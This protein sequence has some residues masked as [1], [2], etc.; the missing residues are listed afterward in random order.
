[1]GGRPSPGVGASD[2]RVLVVE[3]DRGFATFLEVALSGSRE[4]AS[5]RTAFDLAG[6]LEQLADG[7]VGAVL[8]DLNLPDSQGLATLREVLAT[9]PEVAVVVLTGFADEDLA[10]SALRLGAQDWLVKGELEPA[11]IDRALRYAIERTTLTKGLVRAQK[12]EAIGRLASDVAH[13]FNNV[14]TAILGSAHL[15][16]EA[17]TP[18]EREAA[19]ALL[20]RSARQGTAL[21]RQLLSLARN[22]PRHDAVVAAAALVD[23]AIG[24]IRAVLPSS[25]RVVLGPL[26]DVAVRVDPG[27]FDQILLN[28]AVNARDAMA[29]GGT[30]TISVATAAAADLQPAV[31]TLEQQRTFAVFRVAD[32]GSGIDPTAV[33]R[34]FE[35]FFTTKGNRGTGLGLAVVAEIVGRFRGAIEVASQPGTGTTFS[36]IVPACGDQAHCS[37]NRK[38][39]ALAGR[40]PRV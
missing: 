12:L 25:V 13:E 21:S 10:R 18:D 11:A 36:I 2:L 3:D 27:Q 40:N 34:L 31:G 17:P 33:P 9:S 26:A 19:L 14:L 22:P 30:L 35:P 4:A 32:S 28:L 15:I 38:R 29:D 37:P 8:L 20:Q 24:L 7:S 6:A 5:V 1:M 39:P 16:A 23:N